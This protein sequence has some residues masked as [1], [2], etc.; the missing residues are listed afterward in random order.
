MASLLAVLALV[1]ALI[2]VLVLSRRVNELRRRVQALEAAISRRDDSLRALTRRVFQL[3]GGKCAEPPPPEP[4]PVPAPLPAPA[5]EPRPKA[6][7]EWETVIGANWLN[8]LGVAVLI[9]GLSLFLSYSLTNLGPGGRV[10]LGYAV[11]ASLLSLG[12]VLEGRQRYRYYGRGLIGGGWAGLYFTTYAVHGL[13][14]ARLVEDPLAGILLLGAV[15]AGLIA[16]SLRYRSE[17]VTGI[18][19]LVGFL[20][21]ALGRVTWFSVA[22]SVPL[23]VVLLAVAWRFGWTRVA[24]GGAIACY[25]TYALMGDPTQTLWLGAAPVVWL[26]WALFEAFDLADLKRATGGRGILETLMPVNACGLL[27]VT[28]LGQ[29]KADVFLFAAAGAIGLSAAARR[30]LRPARGAGA[31]D[32][33]LFGGYELAAAA[34]TALLVAGS[35]SRYREY[36]AALFQLMVAEMLILGGLAAGERF[37]N[38]LGRAVFFLPAAAATLAPR[39]G[40]PPIE[41]LGIERNGWDVAAWLAVI[42]AVLSAF[43]LRSRILFPALGG[44]VALRVLYEL[45]PDVW[46]APAWALLG[47]GVLL[48]SRWRALGLPPY[49]GHAGLGLSLPC[50]CLV[51]AGRTGE[52]LYPAVVV[53]ACLYL[54][55]FL[56]RR[57]DMARTVLSLAGTAA[58]T[59]LLFWEVSGRVLTISCGLAGASLLVV[60][61]LS[62]ER[63]LRL[64]GLGLLFFCI[65]KVFFWDLNELEMFHRILSFLV[66]GVILLVVSWI[67]TRFREQIRKLL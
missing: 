32:R 40:V 29:G 1:A 54:A 47:L 63:V 14:A 12:V 60:G 38:W 7:I 50:L 36:E 19:F 16:H 52:R 27:G 41:L 48:L 2:A 5:E 9:V 34:A 15:A 31:V 64:S 24:L 67:Y 61:F 10:A 13:P 33:V 37:L 55:Q 20:T 44:V 59:L 6:Q 3:E 4:T 18:A 43:L 46:A 66:L 51:N 56:A 21:L 8:K 65:G 28:L 49:H 26:Y 22:A 45:V 53:T 25:W 39:R 11:S 23:A 17:A 30:S 62:R 58:L 57:G 35:W 42:L